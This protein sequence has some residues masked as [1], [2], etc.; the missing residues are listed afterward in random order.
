[1]KRG[2]G[3]LL[4]ISSLP[5]PYGI[6]TFGKSAYSFIDFL[7]ESG[8][9]YWQVLPLGITGFGDS[10]YQSA[11][12]FAG[13]PYFIDLDILCDWGLLPKEELP[14]PES[15]GKNV[16]YSQLYE[17]R[18]ALLRTAFSHGYEKI[19][20][21]V[22]E[23]V[24]KN[25]YWLDDFSLFMALKQAHQGTPWHMW[26]EPYKQRDNAALSQA[27]QTYAQE[28]AFWQ[29]VQY[30]FFRQWDSLRTYAQ[31]SGITIIGD[32]PIYVSYDSCDVWSNPEIFMLNAERKPILVAGCP[33][34]AFSDTGQLWGNPVYNWPALES[35]KFD[36]WIRRLRQCSRLYDC[37]RID[38]FRGFDEFWGIPAG[39]ETAENGKWYPAPGRALF[40]EVQRQ[41]PELTIIAEDLG[42]LTP[43]VIALRETLGICGTKVLLFAFD[44]HEESDYLPHRYTC[45]SIVYTGT[46]D[47]DTVEGWR[48]TAAKETVAFAEAYL[49]KLPG[50]YLSHAFIRGAYA[51]V[52]DIAIIPMQDLLGLDNS[53]RMNTPSVIGG[54][55]SWRM[56]Q[57]D[58]SRALAE[59]L[60]RLSVLYGRCSR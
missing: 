6:G 43:S 10:P 1:M 9:S 52:S 56:Q 34:D 27:C 38:H 36:W 24:H 28:I 4:H 19:H 60:H 51:S 58:F 22:Q 16:D 57:E 31:N 11:S 15:F 2:S 33:P 3:I 23:F 53:A 12:S 49:C 18:Y 32:I 59:E 25:R 42:F 44:P 50:E 20:N 40:Q 5:S 48:K 54:N 14:L 17:S 13:N 37:V 7:K 39:D 35:R 45:H 41:L 29:F 8:Q 30:L 26:E 21:Q 47:N 55:W 46:H